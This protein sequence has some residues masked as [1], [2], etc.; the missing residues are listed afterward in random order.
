MAAV[1]PPTVPSPAACGG[2][3]CTPSG[4]RF[5]SLAVRG[6]GGRS[7][8]RDPLSVLPAA[9]VPRH[10]AGAS[11]PER[12]RLCFGSTPR[13]AVGPLYRAREAGGKGPVRVSRRRAEAG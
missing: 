11:Y 7:R 10:V 13:G 5:P 3:R 9:N 4:Q 1:R 8:N 2:G 6:A 12:D